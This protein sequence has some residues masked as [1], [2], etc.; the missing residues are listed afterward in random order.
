MGG[1]HQT[2]GLRATPHQGSASPP[3]PSVL[4]APSCWQA[5]AAS[6]SACM[7]LRRRSC[8]G[9]SRY[10]AV[11]SCLLCPRH[12][13]RCLS[14]GM[15]CLHERGEEQVMLLCCCQVWHSQACKHVL[16]L[17]TTK[18]CLHVISSS[19][20]KT[21]TTPPLSLSTQRWRGLSACWIRMLDVGSFTSCI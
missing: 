13:V 8:C 2:E 3:W 10:N 15:T 1:C 12:N 16:F 5:A 18:C 21:K 7:M 6:M 14:C 4:M 17:Q 19:K 9:A 11:L 20:Q